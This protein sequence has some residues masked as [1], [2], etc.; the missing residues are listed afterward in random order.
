[1]FSK[2]TFGAEGNNSDNKKVKKVEYGQI[3][4]KLDFARRSPIFV[5]QRGARIAC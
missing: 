5:V 1:M 2:I 4:S 3:S